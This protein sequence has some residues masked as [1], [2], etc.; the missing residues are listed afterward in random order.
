M[1][2]L[3]KELV[4]STQTDLK[5]SD[6][7]DAGK[8]DTVDDNDV[9][10]SALRN[11]V[12]K[13][14]DVNGSDVKDYLEKAGEINDE[15]DSVVFGLEDENGDI[16]KVYV[17]ASQADS[18]E[19]EMAELLG[20]E[21][22]LETAIMTASQ[23]F[24]IVDVVW[25][26]E[27]DES[28]EK[29]ELDDM[30]I[31]DVAND[32]ELEDEP[33]DEEINNP[34]IKE[35]KMRD[36]E[37]GW[38]VYNQKDVPI[39]GPVSES[40]AR[41]KAEQLGGDKVGITVSYVSDYDI[42]RKKHRDTRP[43]YDAEKMMEAN[44]L[45]GV[46]DG[47]NIPLDA[48]YTMLV[49]RLKRPIEKKLVAFFAL[50]G[51]PGRFIVNVEGIEDNV[52]A[53]ADMLRKN[54]SVRR[55]FDEFY[56]LLASTKGMNDM[57]VTESASKRGSYLQKKFETILIALGMPEQIVSATGPSVTSPMLFKVAKLIDTNA[58]LEAAMNK[59]ALRLGVHSQEVNAM[60]GENLKEEIDVG[61]DEFINT[62]VQLAIELG[63]PE[64]NLAFQRT[65][66]MKS[67]RDKKMSL[68]SRG[69]IQQRMETLLTMI[70]QYSAK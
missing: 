31:D 28:Y 57:K 64:R 35:S 3:L 11:S 61:Q 70:G 63:V 13:S 58:G 51:I 65:A 42:D 54:V 29:D 36:L 68:R 69:M 48:Q 43:K 66:L 59:L 20:I 23:K 39:A 6:K 2:N 15:V 19:T 56:A 67:L 22:D 16:V 25:P 52:R 1:I 32:S 41:K 8:N 60:V 47:F 7:S 44:E 40:D 38:Y 62:V 17:N 9:E 24:D 30:S 55:A 4:Q 37:K 33:K 46:R 14:T 45:D 53:A 10:F 12:F 27:D 34:E 5:Q 26:T 21:D 50:T 49:T 18:F